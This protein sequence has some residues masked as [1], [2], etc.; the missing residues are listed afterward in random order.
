MGRVEGRKGER[1]EGRK[2]REKE[3]TEKTFSEEQR[4]K[5]RSLHRQPKWHSHAPSFHDHQPTE[6]GM[7]G[8]CMNLL[9]CC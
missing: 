9:L 7:V 2:G 5:H 3:K 8:H 4:C 1:K 6:Q